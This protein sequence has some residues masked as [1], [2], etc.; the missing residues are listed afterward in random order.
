MSYEEVDRTF[1]KDTNQC[2]Q[3]Y[4]SQHP[5]PQS[6]RQPNSPSQQPNIAAWNPISGVLTAA[7]IIINVVQYHSAL[8]VDIRGRN[9]FYCNLWTYQVSCQSSRVKTVSDSNLDLDDPMSP[10]NVT[11]FAVA[12]SN[13]ATLKHL[14]CQLGHPPP[15]F[16]RPCVKT[17]EP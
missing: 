9:L 6:S 14:R 17:S 12:K 5:P 10:I 13:S 11:C 16:K 4:I 2:V 8:C 7:D 1:T 3:W 15:P